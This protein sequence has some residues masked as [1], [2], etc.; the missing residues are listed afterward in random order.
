[1]PD[2][3][4]M[5]HLD[6]QNMTRL[7]GFVQRQVGQMAR[8]APVNYDLLASAFAYVSGYPD[9]CH[10]P[11]EDLVY[12]K[13]L[14][15]HPD[16]TSSLKDLVAEH[17]KLADATRDL[18]RAIDESRRNP[19]AANEKLA[20]QLEEFLRFYRHHMAMEEQYFFPAALKNLSRGDWAAIDF[21]LFDQPDPLFDRA[22]EARFAGL[23]DE[24]TRL[25]TAENT[26]AEQREETA[27]LTAMQDVA[28][29]ND[30]MQRSGELLRLARS[31]HGGYQLER[32][33]GVIVCIPECSEGRAAWCAYFF[34]KAMA[35]AHHS[36]HASGAYQPFELQATDAAFRR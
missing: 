14:S 31:S 4:V 28:A 29:F 12:R 1:M 36:L 6:H 24:I 25:G 21:A 17:A 30:A 34:W 26:A 10:H 15:R 3:L 18:S 33:G 23:R 20:S 5:L 9:Q 27:D 22:A 35:Q 13:L 7:L 32:N 16:V 8:G 19:A 2:T 11:K